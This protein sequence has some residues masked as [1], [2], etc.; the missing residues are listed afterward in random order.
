MSWGDPFRNAWNAA[1][2][3]AKAAAQ[4]VA[5][6]AGDLY[7]KGKQLAGDAYDR[8]RAA[9]EQAID[10]AKHKAGQVVDAAKQKA[11]DLYEGAQGKARD[12]LRG[13][14]DDVYDRAAGG[15]DAAKRALADVKDAYA[16]AKNL[17]GKQPAGSPVQHCPGNTQDGVKDP[18]RDGWLMVPQGPNLPCLA[19]PPGPG[20]LAAAQAQSFVAS[21]PCCLAR[22]AGEA[23]RDI[24]YVNGINTT[25]GT[26]CQT[27]NQIAQQTCGRLVG[28]YNATEGMAADAL[29]TGKDR[30]LVKAASM[31]KAIPSLDG[32]NPAVDTLTKTIEQELRDGKAPEIWAHSQGGAVTALALYQ[33]KAERAIATGSENP[34]AGMIVKS[35][36]AAAPKWPDGPAYEHYLHVNDATPTLFGLGH[37]A[38]DDAMNSGLGAK[39]IRFAGDPASALPFTK[40]D[41]DWVPAMTSNHDVA[42]SYL[43]MEK[44]LNGGCP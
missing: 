38:V 9:A 13:V 44:Q 36:G 29:Q 12:A 22:R 26:H 32:R 15:A 24:L 10:A 21:D 30:L 1:T 42:S 2:D 41:L 43:K 39:V 27:L 16:K 23:A 31:G 8:G 14:A 33:A 17:F 5:S 28:I 40:P 19:I 20:A 18:D 25:A 7:D 35:L 6:Q 3:K 4:Q 34:L 37:D 11:A